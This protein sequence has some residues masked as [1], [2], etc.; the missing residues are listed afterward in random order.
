MAAGKLVLLVALVATTTNRAAAAAAASMEGRHEKW[1]AENGRTYEDA[2]EKARRFEVFKANVERIDRFNAGGNR[3][4][5]LGVNVFTDLTDDEFVARY[6]A[7][8]YYSNAT[9]F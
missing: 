3:T 2:A 8:G 9:S 5:S 1:M 4:Y 6:T 7:A